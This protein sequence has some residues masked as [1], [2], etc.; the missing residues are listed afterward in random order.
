M[1]SEGFI[2]AQRGYYYF[3]SLSLGGMRDRNGELTA[4]HI[5]FSF[6][7]FIGNIGIE[8]TY[9]KRLE[10]DLL[11]VS[12]SIGRSINNHWSLGFNMGLDY[13]KHGFFYASFNPQFPGENLKLML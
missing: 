2:A 4:G 5:L 8:T 11:G 13:E 7:T 12:T 3:P 6:P 1:V 10:E 9:D